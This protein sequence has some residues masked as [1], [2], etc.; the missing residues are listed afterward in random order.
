MKHTKMI[1]TAVLALALTA[2]SDTNSTEATDL[3]PVSDPSEVTP[4]STVLTEETTTVEETTTITTT[5]AEL[6]TVSET[7]TETESE[8][9][10][11]TDIDEE[12]ADTNIEI[13]FYEQ[14][15]TRISEWLSKDKASADYIEYI[16]STV[17]KADNI[18]ASSGL[19]TCDLSNTDKDDFIKLYRQHHM[20][21]DE[22]NE[23]EIEWIW[24][25]EVY[26]T[27]DNTDYLYL[28]SAAENCGMLYD[29]TVYLE[30]EL[31]RVGDGSSFITGDE[32]GVYLVT[33]TEGE[34]W[35]EAAVFDLTK[36]AELLANSFE[37][38]TLDQ[39]HENSVDM[40]YYL[41]LDPYVEFT[42]NI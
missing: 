3:P 24:S 42:L 18:P 34:L 15:D 7:E 28:A 29:L 16:E 17:K 35:L 4:S 38:D 25:N 39:E 23:N 21:P 6:T 30:H 32:N 36:G 31:T 20:L 40:K 5:T 9:T 13:S 33:Y 37:Y 27:V 41:G 1:I 14:A 12:S 2:C 22:S 11:V 10:E 8:I 19:S 26:F